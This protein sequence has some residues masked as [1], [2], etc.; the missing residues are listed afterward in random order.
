M[1]GLDCI[2][3]PVLKRIRL[4]LRHETDTPP[5]LMLINHQPASFLGDGAHREIQL[6]AAVA[7]QRAEQFPGQALRMDAKKRRTVT[8]IAEN[9]SQSRLNPLSA[10]SEV[11]LEPESSKQ[12][13][14]RWH[15]S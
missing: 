1:I 12:A 6:I 13:P 5:F 14:L 9:Q 11:P 3:T 10:I 2:K 4:Q 8:E 7:A 15:A